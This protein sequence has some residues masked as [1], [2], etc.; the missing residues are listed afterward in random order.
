MS[1]SKIDSYSDILNSLEEKGYVVIPNIVHEK[2]CNDNIKLIWKW[3]ETNIK[4]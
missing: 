3:L 1:Q 4:R 2:E